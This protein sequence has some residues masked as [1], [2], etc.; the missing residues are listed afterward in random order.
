MTYIALRHTDKIKTAIVGNGPTNLFAVIKER[1]EMEEK[2]F[3]QCIPG[4]DTQK[5]EAL[6]NR[7]VTY[8]ANELNKQSSLLILCGSRDDRV[9][10][11]Q[12]DS[13]AVCL[14]EI[15]YN[16]ELRKFDT[17]HYFSDMKEELDQIIINWFD[18]H[19]K[20]DR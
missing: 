1:P 2:V 16:F 19:L 3:A 4:Y 20:Y 14:R 7:S 12:A 10:P 9:S 6:K 17:D 8:W 18:E 11:A 13:L 15:N 5:N